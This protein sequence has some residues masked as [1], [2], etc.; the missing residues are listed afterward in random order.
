MFKHTLL[1]SLISVSILGLSACDSGSDTPTPE[2]SDNTAPIAKISGQ[3]NSYTVGDTITLSAKDSSDEEDGELSIFS[4]SGDMVS[5]SETSDSLSMTAETAGNNYSVTL[6]VTDSA[7]AT[8]SKTINYR[9]SDPV[10]PGNTRPQAI[11]SG[12][13]NTAVKIGDKITLSASTSTDK[14]DGA[15]NQFEWSSRLL[16]SGSADREIEL[17]FTSAGTVS[18][19]LIVTDSEGDT[20]APQILTFE[21]SDPNGTTNTKPTAKISGYSSLNVKVGDSVI[22]KGNQSSDE[23]DAELSDF[24]WSSTLLTGSNTNDSVELTFNAIGSVAVQLSVTDSGSL[25]DTDTITFNV[26]PAGGDNL[27][28]IISPA[29]HQSIAIGEVLTLSASGSQGDNLSYLWSTGETTDNINLS[30]ASAGSHPITLTITDGNNG[31]AKISI[32]VEVKAAPEPTSTIIYFKNDAGYTP[33]HLYYW[34]TGSSSSEEFPGTEMESLGNDWYS[35]DFGEIVLEGNIIFA[36]EK[37][38]QTENLSLDPSTPCYQGN[39]FV[40]MSECDYT[41]VNLG[42][43][44]APVVTASP[45]AS[46]Y[47]TAQN[48]TLSIEDNEDSAPKLYY[49]LDGST[50]STNDLLYTSGTVIKAED[51]KTSG[52][53]R[54][55]KTLAVDAD[56]NQSTASFEYTIDPNSSS[57][58]SIVLGD[59]IYSEKC[60]SDYNRYSDNLRIYQVMVEAFID[61][62]SNIGYGT[63][64]HNKSHHNGDLQG[65]IDSLDYIKGLGMNAIWLTPIFDSEG[66]GSLDGTGYFTRN[67]FKIDPHWGDMAKAKELVDTAHAKG[68]Y[69]FFDGVFGHHKGGVPSSPNGNTPQGG[70]NPVDYPDSLA[71]YTE[72]A[73]YWISELKIDGWRLDQAYQVPVDAWRD[74]RK[75][76]VETSNSVTY[77]NSEGKTVHPLAYMVGEIWKSELEIKDMGYGTETNR[78]LC[79]NFAF[80]VRYNLVQTYAVEEH[81]AENGKGKMPASNLEAGLLKQDLYPSNARPN[82]MLTNHD[83]VRFGDLLQRGDIAQPDDEEYWQRHK[84]VFGFM[85]A[86]T[87]PITIYYGDEI[88]DEVDGFVY[89]NDNGIYDDNVA[90]NSGLIEGV[91]FT[92]NTRQKDL[93]DYLTH[94]MQIRAQEPALYSGKRSYL[95]VG[96]AD[97]IHANLKQKNGDTILYITNVSGNTQTVTVSTSQMQATGTLTDLID[98]STVSESS[99]SYSISLAP[100]QVRYLKAN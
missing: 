78:G 18:V 70:S 97:V 80:P 42:D 82:L 41:P 52:F 100:W 69:V 8:H 39:E 50:P 22:L 83:I 55:I 23:Q 14:E 43:T 90:R 87:G 71:Y 19:T 73:T 85:A 7:G 2:L 79:S 44:Q 46:T 31:Q 76:V 92:A 13:I 60:D 51:I 26:S 3:L 81:Y 86:Y 48:I 16:A 62:D 45:R 35:H 24:S 47:K 77:T 94:L 57:N 25:T 61:G 96:D 15:V 29:G 36:Q 10:T 37:D 34:Q 99:G 53:D 28:A 75:A 5:G 58:G 65:I 54:L 27:E 32:N 9:I 64:Y 38:V 49:T 74:I 68:L 12:D 30:Y 56:N 21:V 17:E 88:G 89:M 67:Y 66:G 98:N 91:N 72:V 40:A 95:E 20:S 63:G 84:G 1:P 33:P 59:N 93:R 11:I 4:W 6:T